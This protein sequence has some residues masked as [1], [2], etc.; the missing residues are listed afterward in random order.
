M[1]PDEGYD[2]KLL[3]E[4][5]FTGGGGTLKRSPTA[6]G[7]TMEK[8]NTTL[9]TIGWNTDSTDGSGRRMPAMQFKTTWEVRK[10]F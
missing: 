5:V 3:E 2:D 8:M 6:Q 9:N 10:S 1:I 4:S 7:K